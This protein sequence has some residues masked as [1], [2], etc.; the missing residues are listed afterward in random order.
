MPG[1]DRRLVEQERGIGPGTLDGLLEIGA[2]PREARRAAGQLV[3]RLGQIR[4]ER[5]G[6]EVVVP[7][8]AV[9]I[10]ILQLEDLVKEMQHLDM[11]IPPHLAVDRRGFRGLVANAVEL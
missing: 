7:D 4:R 3:E 1:S 11:G 6:V 10:G 2:E 5:R 9:K 8:D